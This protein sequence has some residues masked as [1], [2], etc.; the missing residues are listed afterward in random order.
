[1]QPCYTED[2]FKTSASGLESRGE[3]A[4]IKIELAKTLI[5][6]PLI[7]SWKQ[8]NCSVWDFL[9]T[10]VEKRPIVAAV[11]PYNYLAK[12]QAAENRTL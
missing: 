6:F 11:S 10:V 5:F 2:A 4:C 9:E 12:M 7:H 1:M 3:K 8:W